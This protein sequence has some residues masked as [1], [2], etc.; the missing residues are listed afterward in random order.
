MERSST[1]GV[2]TSSPARW[3]SH[4]AI[5]F[6]TRSRSDWI[7]AR[8]L[9]DILRTDRQT[10]AP[11]KPDSEETTMLRLLG[12]DCAELKKTQTM[13]RNQLRSALLCY[14][15]LAT[16][17]FSDWAS[18]TALAFLKAY[19]THQ[20]A[21]RAAPE[22]LEALLRAH[23]Y[24]R[25]TKKARELYQTLQRA[26]FPV[27]PAMSAA[28][29]TLVA[30]LVAQLEVLNARISEYR[31]EIDTLMQ[32]HPDSAIFTSLPEAGTYLAAR[33]L[34]DLGDDRDRYPD[35]RI[36]QARRSGSEVI[37][38]G[39]LTP[40]MRGGARPVSGWPG[41]PVAVNY[42]PKSTRGAVSAPSWAS[43]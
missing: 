22:A 17:L 2:R 33:M 36:V 32:E 9:A 3:W 30:T 28:K 25:A 21:R 43:K 1:P 14:S 27:R 7:D 5:R 19:P 37:S 34:G 26:P 35:V 41:A 40:P 24:P 16:E 6:S 39:P 23:R 12:R 4:S 13:L 18:P 8:V 42:L 31:K 29:Q 10:Y 38:S 15:P 20:E 11:L